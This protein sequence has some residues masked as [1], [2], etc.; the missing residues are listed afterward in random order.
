MIL[1]NYGKQNKNEGL[2]MFMF[3]Q[4]TRFFK[5]PS[6]RPSTKI[7]LIFGYIL[8]LKVS[9]KFLNLA[10]Y[11]AVKASTECECS[12]CLSYKSQNASVRALNS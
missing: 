9:L 5:K 12:N 1:F 8:E 6:S 3:Q 4:G 7:F 10:S 2:E 11:I